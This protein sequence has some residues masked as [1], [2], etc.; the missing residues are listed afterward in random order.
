MAAPVP[1]R[2][3]VAPVVSPLPL[4]ATTR[5]AIPASGP[6]DPQVRPTTAV[7]TAAATVAPIAHMTAI[8]ATIDA[9]CEQVKTAR[10]KRKAAADV[11]TEAK[12]AKA[13]KAEK[14]SPEE[15]P[16]KETEASTRSSGRARSIPMKY[17]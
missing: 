8:A 14:S 5:I 17:R 4:A 9:P 11:D 6:A 3:P 13:A 15:E 7:T 10:G 16:S 1:V 12:K 2:E